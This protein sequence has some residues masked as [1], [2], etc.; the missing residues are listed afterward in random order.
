MLHAADN[1]G[2]DTDDADEADVKSWRMLQRA[3]ACSLHI[4]ECSLLEV[5]RHRM[6]GN[7]P[8]SCALSSSWSVILLKVFCADPDPALGV[9][10]YDCIG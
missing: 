4:R 2:D 10:P 7:R 5:N 6:C 9:Y 1:E 8:V 3:R